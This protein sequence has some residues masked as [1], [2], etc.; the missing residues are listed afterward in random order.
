MSPALRISVIVPHYD[1]L[2][3]P[4]LDA[5][6]RQRPVDGGLAMRLSAIAHR[7]KALSN[8]AVPKLASRFAAVGVLYRIRLWRFRH[9]LTLLARRV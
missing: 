9:G 4:V 8:P 5:L 6:D 3:R 2:P 7:P 1:D